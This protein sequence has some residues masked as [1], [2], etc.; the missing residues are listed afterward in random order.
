VY[1]LLYCKEG[2][3]TNY[4]L[5]NSGGCRSECNV[6]NLSC[7]Y[8]IL[9]YRGCGLP[10]LTA[11]DLNDHVACSD[12]RSECDVNDLSCEYIILTYRECGLPALTAENLNDHVACPILLQMTPLTPLNL[13]S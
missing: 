8:I 10:A 1:L 11:E 9:T 4:I 12:C 7:E 3:N 6:N 13:H 2:V 5:D